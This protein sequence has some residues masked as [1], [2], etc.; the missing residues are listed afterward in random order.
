MDL[1][2]RTCTRALVFPAR[3]QH[4]VGSGFRFRPVAARR[5]WKCSMAPTAVATNIVWEPSSSQLRAFPGGG[6][7]PNI[8][9]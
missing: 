4:A 6:T 2:V 9:T 1:E 7:G 8:L 3:R 5:W